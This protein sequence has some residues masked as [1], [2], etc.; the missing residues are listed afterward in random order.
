MGVASGCGCIGYI[1]FLILIIPIPLVSAHFGSIIP[2]FCS[3]CK[4]VFVL[5]LL[6]LRRQRNDML[7]IIIS[8]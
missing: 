3:L 7:Y 6:Y 2:T 5:V 8:L 1:D 4:K